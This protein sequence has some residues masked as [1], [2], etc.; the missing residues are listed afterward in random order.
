MGTSQLSSKL[1]TSFVLSMNSLLHNDSKG[2]IDQFLLHLLGREPR[3]LMIVRPGLWQIEELGMN[4]LR[5][6]INGEV[7]GT[8][9]AGSDSTGNIFRMQEPLLEHSLVNK[10]RRDAEA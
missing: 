9:L 8:A 2:A 1:E 4:S 7:K 5:R 10:S 6:Q 3:N